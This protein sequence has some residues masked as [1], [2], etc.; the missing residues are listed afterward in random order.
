MFSLTF[1]LGLLCRAPFSLLLWH[2]LRRSLW[3]LVLA[4]LVAFCLAFA[5]GLLVLAFPT[6]FSLA[7]GFG[8]LCCI[9]FG[10]CPWPPAS[11]FPAAFSWTSP[12]ILALPRCSLWSL[13][14]SLRPS[15]WVCPL[16]RSSLWCSPYLCFHCAFDVAFPWLLSMPLPSV[17]VFPWV[18]LP[19]PWPSLP[20]P[21][22]ITLI[23]LTLI[24]SPQS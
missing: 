14:C 9:L 5:F 17:L 2:S 8:L 19:L 3:P 10:H 13:F 6:A 16:R 21:L 4:F 20:V 1:A 23:N 11:A 15:L 24:P 22:S 18:L 12:S 7:F